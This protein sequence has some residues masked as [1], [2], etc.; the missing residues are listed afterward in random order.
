MH[1]SDCLDPMT[2]T[3]LDFD[4]MI[5]PLTRERFLAEYW[6]RKFVH[7]AGSKGRFS[8]IL[9]WE[10]LNYILAW[11]PPPQPQLRMFQ[12]G[13]MVDVRRYIDGPVGNLRLNPGGLIALLAQ[14]ATM[15]MD[16]V[17]E[18]SPAI[19]ALTASFDEALSSTCAANLY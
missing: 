14:G 19:H 9:P 11:H 1:P 4:Q 6:T 12:E 13:V 15:I 3:V 10:E 2:S 8:S 17:Q 5:A 16:G 7:I 18:V